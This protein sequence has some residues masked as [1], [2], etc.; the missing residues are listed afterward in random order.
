MR[1][2]LFLLLTFLMSLPALAE[3]GLQGVVIDSQTGQPV[4]GA[5]V[6]LDNQGITVTTG[7]DGDFLIN[8]AQP[9]KD[10]LLVLGYGYKDWSKDVE[11]IN[12]VVDNMG[13]IKIES[14]MFSSAAV[15]NMGDDNQEMQLT[16]SQL[17][18]EEGNT[19]AVATLTGTTDNPFYKAAS[20]NF[21]IMRFRVRGYNAEYT[22]TAIN[23]VN[24]NDA[25]RGRFNYSMLGGLNQA[26]KS[27]SI[28]TGLEASSYAFGDVGGTNDIR[29]YAKGFAPGFRGSVAYTNGMYRWRGM[30]TYSTGIMPNG[31][32]MTVSAVGRYADE[33]VIPGSFYNSWGYF[34][35]IQKDLNPHNSIALTT[36]G[37]PTKRASNSATFEEAYR[38]AGTNLY[39]SNWGWQEGK[40]RNARVVEAFDPTVIL[41]WIWK[42]KMG[43]TLNTGLAFH[44]SF[45]ASSALNWY[46]ASDPRPD[47]YRY[48]PSYYEDESTADFYRNQWLY[49]E[50]FRQIDWNSIYNTN[51]M[52]NYLADQTG[53]E[54]ASTYI[55]ENRHSNQASWTINSTLNTRLNSQLTLQGGYAANYTVSSYYKTMKDLLGGRYWLDVDQFA[56]RDFPSDI[57]LPQNDLNNPNRR[58]GVGDRFGYDYNIN[59]FATNVWLQNAWNFARWDVTYGATASYTTY[60]RDG[61]MKNGR[62][63]E[64]SFG[65][66]QH[67][68]FFNWGVKTGVNYKLDG[69]NS[70]SL[71]AYY[72]TRA[73][74]SNNAYVSPRIKDDVITNL[75]SE[76]IASGD[77]NYNWNYRI[78]KGIITAF[79]TDMQKGTERTAFY[80]DLNRT[81]MNYALTDVHKVFKGV[82]LGLSVKL[83]PAVTLNAAANIARYQY[84]NR[85]TGTRS[86]E[87]GSQPDVTQTVY[88][89]NF[90]VGGTPQEA[91]SIG[92]NY[93]APHM[94]FFEVNGCW[95]NRAYIDLSPIRHEKMDNLWTICDTEEDLKARIKD[96]TTQ[97]KLN[98]ALVI[99]MSIGH[100]IYLNRRASLNFNLNLNNLLNNCNI[101]TGGYQ[102]GRFDYK[103]FTTSKYPNKY[104]YAQGFKMYLNVG[105]RF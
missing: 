51:L 72:G 25:A 86:Y 61:K 2:K 99:N 87:N 105:V 26:F 33:G 76:R 77:I 100:V 80:D 62:A 42:P 48:L 8:D 4:A 7:P 28:G 21:S 16:A 6:M 56:E 79:Y 96:I 83:T 104:Y 15:Q 91:Y 68:S 30:G 82:E 9:G 97:E 103:K 32:A 78:F 10:K 85:P 55:L 70:F 24:F 37:A 75:N 45:Y 64:N 11:I 98:E 63:P 94:W 23:G 40:K 5:T 73:P 36:F 95:L 88:L 90:Y 65:E 43:T 59:Q 54:H 22:Q 71:H 69:R 74:L 49:N 92:F 50:D 44:K 18:D 58:I 41:N 66:G 57:S 47:Y 17:E 19:Q 12:N 101:Q 38:L 84:K 34:L 46:N 67:H 81:F 89:K 60:L 93:A 3:T 35:S 13:S 39:N 1:L 14:S 53:T 20:Y 52:N 27:K 29:T 102:Q 31:W